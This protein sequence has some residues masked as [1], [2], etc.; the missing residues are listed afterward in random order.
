MLPMNVPSRYLKAED[1]REEIMKK[2]KLFY[3][4]LGVIL[5]L[6]MVSLN[7]M[8]NDAIESCVNGGN[9]RA[10]CEAGLR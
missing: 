9:S 10:F 1:R 5:L 6:L 7:K 2:E 4:G 3:V 8:T